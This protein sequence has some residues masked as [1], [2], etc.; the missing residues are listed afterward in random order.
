MRFAYLQAVPQVFGSDE[1]NKLEESMNS[2]REEIFQWTG[3]VD[4]DVWVTWREL[5]L[6]VNLIRFWCCR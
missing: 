3:M 6:N 5:C 1:S 2:L 4:D